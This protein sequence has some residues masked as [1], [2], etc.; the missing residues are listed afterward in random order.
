MNPQGKPDGRKEVPEKTGELV[1]GP[2]PV[3]EQG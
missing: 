2:A 3:F 1:T